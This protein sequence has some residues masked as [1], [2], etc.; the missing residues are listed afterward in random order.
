MKNWLKVVLSTVV[1]ITLAACGNSGS[2]N[3]E[4]TGTDESHL[5]VV[6]TNS[7]IADMAEQVGGGLVN[8]HSLVPIGTDPHEHEVLPDDIQKSEEADIV[9][10]NALN[11]ETGNGWF[12]DLMDTTGKVEDEDYFALSKGVE[13]LF[14]TSE[15]QTDQADPHAWLDLQN[16]IKY[17]REIERIFSEKDPENAAAF[18][19]NADAYVEKLTELDSEAKEAFDDIPEDKQLLVTS[20]GAF[21]YF[22]KAYGIEA[23]YIWEINTENQGTPEQMKQIIDKVKSSETPVLFVETSV[24]PRS[25][26][27]VSQET[28]LPIYTA[29][30]TDSIAKEGEPGDSYYDMVK[31][32][33]EK[34][35]DG[36]SQT[37]GEAEPLDKK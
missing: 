33:I 22:A 23:G 3:Q 25:M 31:W 16:G 4:I 35:H 32:N 24:D 12:D 36:L 34:I 37:R 13:P 10:Y 2:A 5:N 15:G 19:D 26:E 11:L 14:L 21:K 17:V 6:A 9:L 1:L 8:I 7:I 28:G 18:K 29:I 27:R 20:E 30:Y